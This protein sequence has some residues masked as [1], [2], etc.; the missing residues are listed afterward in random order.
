MIGGVSEMS[1]NLVFNMPC[2]ILSSIFIIFFL[3]WV[4]A[5]SLLLILAGKIPSVD[6]KLGSN[7]QRRTVVRENNRGVQDEEE[8]T[9][10]EEGEPEESSSQLPQE[11]IVVVTPTC[12][13]P[14]WNAV[15]PLVVAS[16]SVFVRSFML[17]LS[18][19]GAAAMATRS[20]GGSESDSA[21]SIAAHQIAL[22]LWLLC[23]FVCD[24]L[25]AASQA[26]VADRL[27][28]N[29][30]G[31]FFGC[32]SP[33]ANA[34]FVQTK[35]DSKQSFTSDLS[36]QNVVID[37]VRDVSRTIFVYAFALGLALAGSLGL[38]DYSGFLVILFTTDLSTQEALKPL[39]V[40]LIVA[41][42]LNSF[43]FAADGVLQGASLFAYQAKSM[44][45]SVLV[46]FASFFCL[47]YFSMGPDSGSS[48]LLC[49]WYSLLVLQL[50]RGISS[51]LK[52]LQA[53]GPID[54]FH[55]RQVEDYT[56][57]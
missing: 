4:C 38:G 9:T 14:E 22:Q 53:N 45:L 49:V 35:C 51:L 37:G 44:V 19:V 33:T 34:L 48:I 10:E 17:Q 55:R 16:S 5:L 11:T 56:L 28:R 18:I 25:A 32:I 26:L 54:L 13:I 42:P 57:L 29:D 47:G 36:F 15:Q 46:A 52:L 12:K 30:N 41:Q 21:N 20:G 1:K 6:G 31:E 27:G 23:S 50:M 3:E 7:Q 8:E 40:L 24:A 2:G 43:V 39:L